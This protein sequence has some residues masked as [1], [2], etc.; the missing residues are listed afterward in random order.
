MRILRL[1]AGLLRPLSFTLRLRHVSQPLGPSFVFGFVKS[2]SGCWPSIGCLRGLTLRFRVG[3]NVL[4]VLILPPSGVNFVFHQSLLQRVTLYVC[5]GKRA[6]QWV[7]STSACGTRVPV[8]GSRYPVACS[9]N[10]RLTRC[11]LWGR[12]SGTMRPCLCAA[13]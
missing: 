13:A 12:V 6:A 10:S 4:H 3:L 9:A 11:A 2:R 1:G 8:P 7:A 5:I